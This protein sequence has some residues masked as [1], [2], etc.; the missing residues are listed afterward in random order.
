MLASNC[1][2]RRSAD[3]TPIAKRLK[4]SHAEVDLDNQA[5]SED[6]P[7]HQ[8]LTKIDNNHKLNEDTPQ[9]LP[10]EEEEGKLRAAEDEEQYGDREDSENS[11]ETDSDGQ[12]AELTEK[13]SG[14]EACSIRE[15]SLMR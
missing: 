11:S 14:T 13:V 10:G 5:D 6:P 2:R 3:A 8:E 15:K 1:K 4:A 7:G 12:L 9:G